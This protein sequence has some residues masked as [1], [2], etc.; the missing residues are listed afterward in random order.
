MNC[1]LSLI[2]RHLDFRSAKMWK[3]VHLTISEI[4]CV[5]SW[6]TIASAEAH[7]WISPW[8]CYAEKN[9]DVRAL[10]G[11]FIKLLHPTFLED[12]G[13]LLLTPSCCLIFTYAS[14]SLNFQG[15]IK[16]IT[17]SLS[18]TEISWSQLN[19]QKITMI[20]NH[21]QTLCRIQCSEHV[22]T[23]KHEAIPT[24]R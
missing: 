21:K 16:V 10:N 1:K 18:F 9:M 12:Q 2:I 19:Q 11:N 17:L 14:P 6:G 5:H 22:D 15:L 23:Q 7:I 4:Q 24:V 3:N 8:S 13:S 20:I